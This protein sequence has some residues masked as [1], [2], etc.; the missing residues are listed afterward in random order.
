MPCIVNNANSSKLNK[1]CT[2]SYR[3]P[4]LPALLLVCGAFLRAVLPVLALSLFFLLDF[5]RALLLRRSSLFLV[6]LSFIPLFLP[7]LLVG[8]VLG[9]HVRNHLLC[10]RHTGVLFCGASGPGVHPMGPGLLLFLSRGSLAFAYAGNGSM[11]RPPWWASWG[12][13]RW[14]PTL[15]GLERVCWFAVGLGCFEIGLEVAGLGGKAFLGHEVVEEIVGVVER[16][17]VVGVGQVVEVSVEA[18]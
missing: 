15:G 5:F 18:G 14:L 2:T 1:R 11:P 17:G 9:H 13:P 16:F 6:P 3:C 4:Y 10:L 8:L 12:R 7:C